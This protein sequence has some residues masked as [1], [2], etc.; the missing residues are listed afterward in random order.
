MAVSR[1]GRDPI[2]S[3]DP[4][5]PSK[6]AGG[7]ALPVDPGTSATPGV[8][9]GETFEV[10]D[11]V[12][13][14]PNLLSFA[15]LLGV[16]LFLYLVL[17]PEADGW[18]VVT[19]MV[20]GFTDYLDGKL[21]RR[22]NQI[23]RIGQLLDPL[24]DRLYIIAT[25]AAFLIRGVVPWWL[26]AVLL[27]RDLFLLCLLPTLRSHGYG[28][29]PVH[30][31]GKAAT[32][33]LLYA[34]P[35]VLVGDGDSTFARLCRPLGWAFALWGTALYVWAGVL[36]LVQVVQLVRADRATPASGV[37]VGGTAGS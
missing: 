16:P 32:F 9:E 1:E 37:A 20:S 13:T 12:L 33:N 28:P 29:L 31:L 5:D 3:S 6:S 7:P 23:T 10:S 19:L 30:F 21:A 34:F 24:A 17:G 8:V 25:L 4:D 35:L 26:V 27:G 22:W 11:A 15:R 2:T 36:Y 14:I 18:A